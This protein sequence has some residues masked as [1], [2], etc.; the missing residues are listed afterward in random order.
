MKRGQICSANA[1]FAASNGNAEALVRILMQYGRYRKACTIC[2]H[3]LA[4]VFYHIRSYLA[5]TGEGS[6]PPDEP[7][8]PRSLLDD[9]LRESHDVIDQNPSREDIQ[10]ELKSVVDRLEKQIYIYLMRL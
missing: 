1:G 5:S 10:I 7:W 6:L 2:T 9:L 3:L 4:Q 8:I